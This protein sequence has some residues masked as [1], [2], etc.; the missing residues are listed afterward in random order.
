MCVV[1]YVGKSAAKSKRVKRM[2][3]DENRENRSISFYFIFQKMGFSRTHYILFS[4]FAFVVVV[5]RSTHN[6]HTAH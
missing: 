4:L 3:Y 1:Y 2:K 6:T 5:V